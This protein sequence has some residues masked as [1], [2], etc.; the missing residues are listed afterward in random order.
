[1]LLPLATEIAKKEGAV[2][3]L[4]HAENGQLVFAQHPKAGKDLQAIL[5]RVFEEYPGK[6]GGTRDFVRAKL[7]EAR[8]AHA[9]VTLGRAQF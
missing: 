3:L 4:A 1:M 9:A 8:N 5:K 7:A 6:G 2:A